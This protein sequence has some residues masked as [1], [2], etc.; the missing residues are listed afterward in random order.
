[1]AKI[2]C[3]CTTVALASALV[4]SPLGFASASAASTVDI[5]ARQ[6]HHHYRHHYRH[7]DSRAALNM[8]GM[9]MGTIAGLAARDA[10]RHDCRYYGNCYYYGAPPSPYYHGYGPYYRY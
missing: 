1:M 6:R 3:T 7:N 10:A 4:L 5:C 2:A 9:M 8:F